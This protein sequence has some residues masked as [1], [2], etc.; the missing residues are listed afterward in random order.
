MYPE[1]I[2]GIWRIA[3]QRKIGIKMN[4]NTL[5]GYI[6][7]AHQGIHGNGDVFVADTRKEAEPAEIDTEYRDVFIADDGNCIEDGAI[8]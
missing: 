6:R 7:A 1:F 4:K 2:Q 3:K 8:A 5:V